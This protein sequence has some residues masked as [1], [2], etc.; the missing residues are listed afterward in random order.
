MLPDDSRCYAQ[1]RDAKILRWVSTS[2]G[3]GQ[4]V[5]LT[6]LRDGLNLIVV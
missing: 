4:R 2:E 1:T 3:V 6:A 5:A